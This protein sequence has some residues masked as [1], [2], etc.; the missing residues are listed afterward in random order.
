MVFIVFMTFVSLFS[1]NSQN[2]GHTMCSI[3]N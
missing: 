2:I 3:D 1:S